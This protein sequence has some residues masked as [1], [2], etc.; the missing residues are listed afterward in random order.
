MLIYAGKVLGQVTSPG[1]CIIFKLQ[2]CMQ[3][4]VIFESTLSMHYAW[5]IM[6]KVMHI[7]I[8]CGWLEVWLWSSS[9]TRLVP[10]EWAA[11]DSFVNDSSWT[12][13]CVMILF[14]P[15][16]DLGSMGEGLSVQFKM[17]KKMAEATNVNQG[18]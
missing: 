11:I 15:I 5:C 17:L 4:V 12:K 10:W 14:P 9:S 3:W 2:S 7:V 13:C 18:R 1:N 6:S 8:R 16:K